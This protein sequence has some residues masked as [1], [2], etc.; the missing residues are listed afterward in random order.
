MVRRV[1]MLA[2]LLVVFQAPMFGTDWR[3]IV[4]TRLLKS[5]V[6]LSANCSGFVI[7]EE[8]DYVLTAK[9]CASDDPEKVVIV[10]LL[11]GRV[12]ASDIHKDLLVLHVP[13]IDKPALHLAEK[14]AQY[15]EAVASF[16]YGG[17][18]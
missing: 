2:V 5:V 14:D 4:E 15:G 17:G 18:Y 8:K 13:T 11:P 9:H 7:N 3:T 1:N 10:D 16:G 6:Q 12:V